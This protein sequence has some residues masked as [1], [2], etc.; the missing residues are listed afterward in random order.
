MKVLL[1]FTYNTSLEDWENAGFIE[2]EARYY[3]HFYDEHNVDFIFLTYG[4]EKDLTIAKNYFLNE[5]IPIYNNFKK[6]KYKTLNILKSLIFPIYINKLNLD[7]DIIKTNQLNGS[8]V[9]IILS[10]ITK[11]PL[12]VRTG[13]DLFTFKTKESKN[14]LLTKFFYYLTKISLQFSSKYFSTSNTDIE[15]LVRLFPKYKQKIVYMPNWV[16]DYPK[17]PNNLNKSRKIITVG[18]LEPQKNFEEMIRSLRNS[19]YKLDIVGSGSL[20]DKLKQLAKEQN[21]EINFIGKIKYY[22]LMNKLKNYLFFL[23]T[24][25][26]EGNPKAILEAM[27]SGCIVLAKSTPN[28]KE[29]I[30]HDVNG[31][32][33][34]NL[35]NLIKIL[36]DTSSDKK[37]IK[38]ISDEAYNSVQNNNK[39]SKLAA[40]EYQEF[41]KLFQ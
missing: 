5:V 29:I 7:F 31:L 30:E 32:I 3:K 9:A 24:S 14:I 26:Y 11:K 16:D 6:S 27:N 39:L 28:I 4:K 8:W 19:N 1:I 38:R 13:F 23:S 35:D 25:N 21:F 37:K 36:N 40:L 34:D 2:R 15:N 17:N 20:E 18:R 22:E 41:K 33:Y 10:L 12:I